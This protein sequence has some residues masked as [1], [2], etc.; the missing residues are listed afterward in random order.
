MQGSTHKTAALV[1]P[2]CGSERTTY[3]PAEVTKLLCAH[4]ASEALSDPEEQLLRTPL[5]RLWQRHITAEEWRRIRQ[6]AGASA[7]VTLHMLRH[8]HASNLNASGRDVVTVQRALG[9]SQPSIT[10]NTYSRL[11]LSAEDRTRAATAAFMT[12]TASAN[13]CQ[14]SARRGT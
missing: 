12:S 8:T 14:V 13:T 4:V 9:H 3:V 1:P 5:G 6:A 7:D 10:L 11:L 2:K